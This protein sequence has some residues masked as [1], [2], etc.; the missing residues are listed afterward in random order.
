VE[1]AN[2]RLNYRTLLARFRSSLTEFSDVAW[3][4]APLEMTDRT[5]WRRT[6][7]LGSHGV[8]APWPRYQSTYIHTY[9]QHTYIHTYI[10]TYLLDQ[11]STV[12]PEK[13][14]G[15]QLIKK[16]PAFY[17]TQ[18][19]I[20]AF[21]GDRLLSLSWASPIQS[22]PPQP[23][24]WRSIL[25]LSSHLHLCLLS[26]LFPSGYPIKTLYKPLP[27]PI[28]ATCPTDLILLDFIS[29]TTVGVLRYLTS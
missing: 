19:F 7:G 29:H 6:K 17:G 20:A 27:F 2:Y 9:I 4:T 16:F 25:I 5:K 3:H 22:I 26:G 24:S 12:L 8:V 18:R 28:R 15:L 10:H 13:L 21:T 11:W 1:V 23:T 14:T